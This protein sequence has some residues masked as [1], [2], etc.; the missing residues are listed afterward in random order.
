MLR[1]PV[2]ASELASYQRDPAGYPYRGFRGLL[3]HMA[4][5]TRN[6]VRFTGTQ[7][8]IAMLT[9]PTS[10][11]SQAFSL[12]G[13][14]GAGQFPRSTPGVHHRSQD[15]RAHLTHPGPQTAPRARRSAARLAS[16][17]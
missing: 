13:A 16:R 7:V 15:R 6:Q 10:T 17:S 5:L 4:T 1:T 3:E 8:I 11:Q 2:P 12:L 9:E 14:K